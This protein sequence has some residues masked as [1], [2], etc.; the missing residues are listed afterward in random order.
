MQFSKM[1]TLVFGKSS[2]HLYK[3]TYTLN[4]ETIEFTKKD[5]FNF[6]KS[7]SLLFNEDN[8]QNDIDNY[9]IK[10]PN[11]FKHK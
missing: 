4:Q 5:N 9:L 10:F 6:I 7:S 1:D 2:L 8:D 11:N 3:R